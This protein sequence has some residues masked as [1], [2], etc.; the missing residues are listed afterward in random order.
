MA[1]ARIPSR[2]RLLPFILIIFSAALIIRLIYV[3]QL[4]AMPTFDLPI[5]DEG[6]HLELAQQI[7]SA[8]GLPDEPFFR[9]PLY[10]YFLALITNIAD[11]SMATARVI[12]VVLGSL[13]PVLV[14]AVGLRFFSRRIALIGAGLAVFYPTFIYYD[15]SLLITFLITILTA[16]LVY[17]LY[18]TQEKPELDNFIIAGLILGVAGLARPNILL[19]GPALVIWL[20]IMIVPKLGRKKAIAY[21]AAMA[22][23]CIL[24]ISP[25]TIR[26]YVVA[27]D[28]TFISWQGGFNFYLGNNQAA[29]GWSATAPGIDRG[30]Q[31][32]YREA[33][34]TA[35]SE[36]R[37]PLKR[38]EISDYWYGRTFDEIGN[39]PGNFILLLFKKLRYVING[40]EIP[41]NQHLYLARSFSPIIKSLMFSKPIFFPYGILA[42]LAIIGFILSVKYWRKFLILYLL[43]GSYTLSLVLFF[44][45]ARFR[46][47]LLPFLI[48]F[49]VFGIQ[50]SLIYFKKRHTLKIAIISAAF[51]LLVIES[52]HRIINLSESQV[53]ADNQY[54]LG[55]SYLTHFKQKYGSG[56]QSLNP[57][58]TEEIIMAKK[59]LHLALEANPSHAL[60]YNDLGTIA[61][62]SEQPEKAENYFNK[63]INAD[64]FAYQS[65][66]NYAKVL[67]LQNSPEKAL[68]ILSLAGRRF[69][70]NEEVQYNLGHLCLEMGLLEQANNALKKALAINPGNVRAR[71]MNTYVLAKMN[72]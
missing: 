29:D 27:N 2:N 3:H 16:L 30:W 55:S 56:Y 43:L 22:T 52:N 15:A 31:S 42:P 60:A 45:C 6:Y 48:I 18:R 66:I 41:N 7:N 8:E 35:E 50:Q 47:P 28:F 5:M 23:A 14:F 49:A 57:K 54:L 72:Q 33:I 40:Y 63:A 37:R 46:Q 20:W 44:V 17:Q 69:P 71:D 21:Y 67:A 32:G 19:M 61:I 25:V 65:Y 26:N 12:Q 34:A 38:S 68:D 51:V 11:G 64:P 4:S 59:H 9:A 13:L 53:E 10:P 70:H 24:M 62:R 1:H 58:L 36:T 39:S